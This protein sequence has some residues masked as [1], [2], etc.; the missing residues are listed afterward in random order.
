MNHRTHKKATGSNRSTKGR[1]K[2]A[3]EKRSYLSSGDAAINSSDA[4]RSAAATWVDGLRFEAAGD[5]DSDRETVAPA[6]GPSS[7]SLSVL[8]WNILADSYCRPSSQTHLPP[9]YKKKVFYG[10]HRRESVVRIL[11]RFALE[12]RVDVICLQEVDLDEIKVA[13]D[14]CGYDSIETSRIRGSGGGAGGRVDSCSIFARKETWQVADYEVIRLDDL[15]YLSSASPSQPCPSSADD[16]PTVEDV[17]HKESAASAPVYSNF[18]GL[19]QSFQRRNRAVLAR[20]RHRET[21]QTV[22]VG[23]CH[24]YWVSDTTMSQLC[25]YPS[26]QNDGTD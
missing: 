4:R 26:F 1:S 19:Q 24:L 8:S 6:A 3:K 23:N 14:E 22:V 2:A 11:K 15:S 10:K 12:E 13:L 20:V 5:N 16:E 9:D 21:G 25:S 18:Q 7:C 17:A